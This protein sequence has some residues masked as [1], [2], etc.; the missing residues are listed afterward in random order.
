MPY[1]LDTSALL[2]HSRN[3]KGASQ[4]QELFGNEDEEILLCSISLA[5][6]ARRMRELK[7]TERAI[8]DLLSQYKE[9][10]DEIITVDESVATGA[11]EISRAATARLPLVDAIIASAA[12]S[13]DAVLVH[14]DAHMR[15]IPSSFVRQIDLDTPA[16]AL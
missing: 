1:L 15:A 10:I 12:R 2:A 7:A 6:F 11:D 4:V 16:A 3:E 13:S 5:E 8:A 9:L 14:R